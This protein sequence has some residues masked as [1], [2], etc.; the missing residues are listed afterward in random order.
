MASTSAPPNFARTRPT[1]SLFNG[2]CNC[3][4]GFGGGGA[5]GFGGAAP[6]GEATAGLA[7]EVDAGAALLAG[8]SPAGM[9]EGCCSLGSSAIDLVQCG[10]GHRRNERRPESQTTNARV[11][12]TRQK[13]GQ[14][15]ELGM[16][17]DSAWKQMNLRDLGDQAHS[18]APFLYSHTYPIS[19]IPRNTNIE[20]SANS[21]R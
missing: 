6:G 17:F 14:S 5:A 19:R 16:Q 10:R 4:G 18:S 9:P 21:P 15:Q 13:P 3:T 12:N 2:V 8:L 20:T 11:S 1:N 7:G